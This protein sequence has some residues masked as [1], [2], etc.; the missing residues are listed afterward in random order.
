QTRSSHEFLSTILGNPARS[1]YD[2]VREFWSGQYQG[3]DFE[4]FWQRSLQ[5]GVV[6][7]G[8]PA[9]QK[10]NVTARPLAQGTVPP[11]APPSTPENLDVIFRPDPSVYDGSFANNAWLQ[12]LQHP[13][14][15]LTWD[16]AVLIGPKTAHNLQLSD[17]D[18]V[19]LMVNGSQISGPV[20]IM[21]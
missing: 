2:L 8:Q 15:N 1:N 21:P 12:E 13:F 4:N 6:R 14:T 17:E 11:S 5:D 7:N 16:N 20:W 3:E 18:V 9:P 19:N 10:V